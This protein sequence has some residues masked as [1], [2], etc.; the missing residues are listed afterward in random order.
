MHPRSWPRPL[1][2]ALM[3]VASLVVMWVAIE[4]L[5]K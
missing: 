1:L 4:G 2:L 3:Y 5:L